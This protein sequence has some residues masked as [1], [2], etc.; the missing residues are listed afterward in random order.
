MLMIKIRKI[1]I[2]FKEKWY[3]VAFQSYYLANIG[4][5]LQGFRVLASRESHMVVLMGFT[6]LPL[7]EKEMVEMG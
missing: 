3:L 7:L 1:G 2:I 6:T 4:F 5:Y